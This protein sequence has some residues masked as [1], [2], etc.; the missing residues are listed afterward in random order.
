[1]YDVKIGKFNNDRKTC[2]GIR[3]IS[4]VTK[5]YYTF[6]VIILIAWVFSKD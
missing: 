4:P 3:F 6:A 2:S 5:I 1:M